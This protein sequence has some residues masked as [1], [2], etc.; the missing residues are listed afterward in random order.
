MT[1]PPLLAPLLPHRLPRELLEPATSLP[2]DAAREAARRELSDPIYHQTDPTLAQRALT[3][4]VEH[5][6]ALLD[7]AAAASPGGRFGLVGLVT[8]AIA[9]VVLLRAHVGRLAPPASRGALL[10]ATLLTADDH[11]RAAEAAAGRRDW[12]QAI[13]DQLR[14]VVRELEQRGFL[15]S[16]PGRTADEVASEAGQSL[17]QLSADLHAAAQLFDEV[18]YGGRAAGPGAYARLRDL[19]ARVREARLAAA[20]RA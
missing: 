16:R 2:R 17:P 5:L 7:R 12:S 3:W 20:G 10:D 14:A 19:D 9:L 8:L 15:D 18:W 13:R 4:L 11:R 1:I 6:D